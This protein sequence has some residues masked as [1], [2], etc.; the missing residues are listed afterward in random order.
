MSGI[1]KFFDRRNEGLAREKAEKE[2]VDL[3]QTDEENPNLTDEEFWEIS[4]QFIKE[5]R[6]SDKNQVVILQ[7]ILEQYTP[8]KIKQFAK[9]YEE[10]NR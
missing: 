6:D 7:A 1:K 4:N 8:L 2:G 3:K 9:R 5:S 10:L